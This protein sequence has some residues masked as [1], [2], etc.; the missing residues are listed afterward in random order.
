M[1]SFNTI[2][3]QFFRKFISEGEIM[4]SKQ[5]ISDK[6]FNACQYP[7]SPSDFERLSALY[8]ELYAE[9][10]AILAEHNPCAIENGKCFRGEPC[11]EDCNYLSRKKGCTV[12][13]LVCKLFLCQAAINKFPACA[14]ALSTLR[15]IAEEHHI[16]GYRAS[17][18]DIF[19]WY[20][21][22]NK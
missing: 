6:I 12:Q 21:I 14:A 9:A 11:C 3:K 10:S 20:A 8:D 16:L 13:S 1:I 15:K 18:E 7:L 22:S 19:S 17:K 2:K 5:T 4:L